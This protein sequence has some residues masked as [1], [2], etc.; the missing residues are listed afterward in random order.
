MAEVLTRSPV[1]VRG[2]WLLEEKAL[3]DLDTI[4]EEHWVQRQEATKEVIEK[5]ARKI[6]DER[7]E[8]E[9][10]A[11]LPEEEKKREN[12]EIRA[13]VAQRY[14]HSW[15]KREVVLTFTSAKVLRYST[16]AQILKAI[17]IKKEMPQ[18][19]A[20]TMKGMSESC[21]IDIPASTNNSEI[22]VSVYP[23]DSALNRSFVDQI[24]HWAER[25]RAPFWQCYWK[26]YFMLAWLLFFVLLF[27]SWI[28]V[29]VWA[30]VS[31]G[32]DAV[33]AE[34]SSLLDQGL[35]TKEDET[36]ALHLTLSL[37]AGHYQKQ[38]SLPP[39]W[40]WLP[41]LVG[42][43]VA[44]VLSFPPKTVIGIGKGVGTIASWQRWIRLISYTVPLLIF[45]GF[46][47]PFARDFLK[48]LF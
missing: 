16:I 17:S 18:T 23:D 15:T 2:F 34:A 45:T 24:E 6:I 12:K 32:K 11:K 37:L 40:M 31:P 41:G 10:Y 36:K 46:I 26:Q 33:R 29:L 19:L 8:R 25:N 5:D 4:L 13:Q 47:I 39:F 22:Y 21:K 7:K 1:Y 14:G 27:V 42:L 48:T 30:S 38:N 3:E 35:K 43:V 44:I 9:S 28:T 20:I